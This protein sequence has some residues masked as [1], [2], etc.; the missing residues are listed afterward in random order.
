[1]SHGGCG[2]DGPDG[3]AH[4]C[5]GSLPATASRR[6]QP[7]AAKADGALHGRS[8]RSS[9]ASP[10]TTTAGC[11]IATSA[12]TEQKSSSS[13]ERCSSS[14][15]RPSTTE[16]DADATCTRIDMSAGKMPI[17]SFAFAA[18]ASLSALFWPCPR[19]RAASAAPAAVVFLAGPPAAAAAAAA[20]ASP[21]R[22]SEPVEEPPPLSVAMAAL[23]SLTLRRASAAVAAPPTPR[24]LSPALLSPAFSSMSASDDLRL[25]DDGLIAPSIGGDGG[26]GA[27]PIYVPPM[28]PMPP[29]GLSPCESERSSEELSSRAPSAIERLC[30]SG[31]PS[32]ERLWLCRPPPPKASLSSLSTLSALKR[33]ER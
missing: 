1:M 13:I 8:L 3:A 31:R 2:P 17:A 29:R 4:S 24:P 6:T 14:C 7:S 28:P 12:E 21:V 26:G 18:A 9:H 10:G 33:R 22:R 16:S 25:R 30:R 11:E 27:P 15:G 19:P 23:P 5:S 20:A 32:P